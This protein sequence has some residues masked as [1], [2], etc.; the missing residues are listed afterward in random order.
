MAVEIINDVFNSMS[1]Y[2]NALT[3]FGYKKQEDVNKLLIYNFIEEL[4]TGD[5]RFFIN[6]ADYRLI[7]QAL[8]CLYGS[9]CLMPYPQY[10]NNDSLFGHIESGGLI[11]PR[12]TEDSNLRFIEDDRSIE[13]RFKASNYDR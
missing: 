8:S 1:F 5:M 6:E 12:I 7:E 13:M 4:L 10:A 11:I 2:F 9:S 3:Q